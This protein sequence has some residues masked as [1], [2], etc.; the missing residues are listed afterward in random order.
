MDLGDND[1]SNVNLIS[2]KKCT[3]LMGDFDNEGSYIC[4]GT[5]DPWKISEISNLFFC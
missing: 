4:I 1:V 5:E 2:Y 3:T